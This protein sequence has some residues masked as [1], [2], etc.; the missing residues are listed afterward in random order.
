MLIKRNENPVNKPKNQKETEAE[1]SKILQIPKKQ[2]ASDY[3]LTSWPHCVQNFRFFRILCVDKVSWP[4]S[5]QHFGLLFIFGVFTGLPGLIVLWKSFDF[6]DFFV[7][8][9]IPGPHS[10]QNVGCVGFFGYLQGFL[11]S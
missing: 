1:V 11:A 5:V 7:F 6:Y 10:V 9:R 8:T 2:S 4:H 3:A